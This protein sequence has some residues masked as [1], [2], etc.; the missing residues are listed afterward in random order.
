MTLTSK[1][2]RVSLAA[3]AEAGGDPLESGPE[4]STSDQVV[5]Y[6]VRD[7]GVAVLTLHRPERLNAWTLAMEDRYFDLL[8]RADADDDVRAIV[9]TGSGR[10]FSPGVDLGGS[11]TT[12]H[13]DP[14]QFGSLTRRPTT[15]PLSV[16]KPL[17]AAINGPVAGVS[18]VQTLQ[19]DLR[20][21]APGV[22]MTFAFPRLGLVAE[23]SVSW[24]LPRLVGT[25]RALDLLLSGRVVTSEEALALG[26][27]NRVVPAAELVDEA[28]A[29]A[30]DL[31][32]NCS[33]ASL[34]VIKQQ[35]YADWEVDLES[36]RV[37][38]ARLMS[39]SLAGP[40]FREGVSSFLEKRRPRFAPVGKGSNSSLDPDAV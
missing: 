8:L 3:M 13:D 36:A 39:A 23:Y 35:V 16:R 11:G 32:A 34:A 6:E 37:R 20:F 17:I 4:S 25:S 30:A 18:L 2:G 5:L 12:N 31:A 1:S 19:C 22:K 21:A 7:D 27:V 38:V 26:L 9:V 29:Y 24:L 14:R 15:L 33:P 28:I 10:G 40:D